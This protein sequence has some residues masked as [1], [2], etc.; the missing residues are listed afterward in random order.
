MLF[1]LS[2]PF[3]TGKRLIC[4]LLIQLNIVQ[5]STIHLL[6]L[7]N[8]F[9]ILREKYFVLVCTF[10]TAFIKFTVPLEQYFLI[11]CSNYL[12]SSLLAQVERLCSAVYCVVTGKFPVGANNCT[13][14]MI[15]IMFSG[16]TEEFI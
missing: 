10:C 6:H 11:T 8:H 4:S 5:V 2:D 3:L 14:F 15:Q 13:F 16:R 9:K 1:L 7:L 12:N